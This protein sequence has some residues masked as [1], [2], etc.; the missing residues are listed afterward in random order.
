MIE[1]DNIL[2]SCAESLPEGN[3][4]GS[5]IKREKGATEMKYS[6]S[7]T[8]FQPIGPNK[9]LLRMIINADPQLS[10]VPQWF[11]DWL[12]RSI[13]GVALGYMR[14]SSAKLPQ[15]YWDRYEEKKSFYNSIMD[16]I[17]PLIK[18]E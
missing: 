5:M 2:F 9:T 10:L 11:L 1:E 3:Y 13:T 16:R 4:F 8:Y 15:I 14:D 18:V 7:A 17:E 12:V 6:D